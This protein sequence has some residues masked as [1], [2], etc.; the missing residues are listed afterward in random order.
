M[1]DLAA[2]GPSEN[3]GRLALACAIVERKNVGEA[4]QLAQPW[5][6]DAENVFRRKEE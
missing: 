6:E 1:L 4:V 3:L 5:D 2:F